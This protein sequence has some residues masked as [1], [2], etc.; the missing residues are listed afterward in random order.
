M[1]KVF[2]C[3]YVC[4]TYTCSTHRGQK[5]ASNPLELELIVVSHHVGAGEQTQ[6]L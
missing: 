5:K 6:V 1:Y 4:A 2:A 3:M